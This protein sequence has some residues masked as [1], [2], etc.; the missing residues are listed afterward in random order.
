MI[1][2]D[3]IERIVDACR[4][5]E[6]VGDFVRLTKR[7]ANYI[8]L[9]PFH[10]EKTPSFIVSPVKGIYKCFGCGEAGDAVH[11]VMQ[12]EHYS[13]PEALRYLAKKYSIDIV[14]AQQTEA[15]KKEYDEKESLY[16]VNNYAKDYF[17]EQLLHTEEGRNVGLEYFRQR[18]FT[19]PTIAK[20]QLGYCPAGRDTFTREAMQKGYS[21]QLL[22]R[23]GLTIIKDNN[24]HLD[25][26][27]E[28][29]MFPIH[30]FSGRVIAFG[31]RVMTAG[32]TEYAAKYVN[33]PETDI[34]HKSNVLYGIFMAKTAIKKADK[35]FLVEGYTDVI[36]FHQAGIENVVAS[37]GTSLTTEQVSLIKKLTNNVTIIYD[38]DNA[39]IK[40]ALRGISLVLKQDMNVRIV[41]LPPEDDPDSFARHHS[42]EECEEYIRTHEADFIT[43]K[44]QILLKD[45]GE[46]PIK[47]AEVIN[48][49]AGDV[50]MVNDTVTRSIY[51][52]QCSDMFSIPEESFADTV[53]KKHYVL[54]V[55]AKA[56]EQSENNATQSAATDKGT[57]EAALAGDAPAKTHP[58]ELL[59]VNKEIVAEKALLKL[60][61]NYGER[62]VYFNDDDNSQYG[63]RVDQYVYNS[64]NDD[65]LD[66]LTPSY[67]QLYDLYADYAEQYECNV[68]NTMLKHE[69]ESTRARIL[70]LM[71]V[72]IEVS[73]NWEE[74]RQVTVHGVANDEG[75][76][77]EEAV[78]ILQLVRL[79]RLHR[80]KH[81]L[82]QMLK[83]IQ[84]EDEET[85]ILTLLSMIVSKTTEIEKTL[86]T[87]Y[88]K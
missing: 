52:Q 38:G 16:A 59:P 41:L 9:C 85:A 86:G 24:Y 28:R 50:A 30:N 23:A 70:E 25:R 21:P 31:G 19:D 32:K 51:V 18:E 26:F 79:Y 7:G 75:K 36:S 55:D 74:K 45:A 14:E 66:V 29:V 34:Y 87:A 76:L 46:D 78:R 73:P 65:E 60:L 10:N 81:I 71:E 3:D 68:V 39:G 33:S 58:Q 49:I 13:Y 56:K 88:R 15:Q 37:S 6:V 40:A 82:E 11:F 64:M 63:M 54:V 35:C 12:H 67:K 20:F 61:I 22:E 2:P 62:I 84:D 72:P 1:K 27:R 8:G 5:E 17:I 47:R 44:T 77:L 69:N 42:L 57:V 43:F 53:R 80:K 48:T 4:I 83:N